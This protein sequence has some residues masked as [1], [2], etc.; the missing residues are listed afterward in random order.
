MFKFHKRHVLGSLGGSACGTE[1]VMHRKTTS[2]FTLIELMVIVAIIGILAVLAIPNFM[3]FQLRTKAAEAK[4]ILAA[5]RQSE[6]GYFG[7]FGSY[8]QMSQTPSTSPISTKRT[9]RLCSAVISMGD[10]GYCIMGYFPEG[11]TYYSYAV[12]TLNSNGGTP[13]VS[14]FADAASDIDG[15]GVHNLWGL[16]V[17]E[18]GSSATALIGTLGCTGVMDGEGN[19][20]IRQVGSCGVGYGVAIF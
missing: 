2:G 9:W 8:I 16:A 19:P 6:G 14:Y 11:P 18:T 3:R 20:L 12:G 5:V 4:T 7:E 13:N 17:P 1:D 15:D 10:A